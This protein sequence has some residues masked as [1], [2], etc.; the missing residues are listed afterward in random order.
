VGEFVEWSD[1]GRDGKAPVAE[2][3]VVELQGSGG[4]GPGGVD[5]GQGDYQPIGWTRG[6][7]DGSLYLIRAEGLDKLR[8]PVPDPDSA[9]RVGED[10]AGFL[11]VTEQRPERDEGGLSRGAV[12]RFQ[13]GDD[14]RRG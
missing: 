7:V 8:A 6:V 4:G 3:D 12:Q 2:V 9:G 10:D 11:A 5:G 13:G 1:V 14:V